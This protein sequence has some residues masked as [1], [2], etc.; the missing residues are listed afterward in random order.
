MRRILFG[1]AAGTLGVVG[2]AGTADVRDFHGHAYGG[3]HA[4]YHRNYGHRFSGG[5]YYGRHDH[6]AW[7]R[8]DWDAHYR[9]WQYWDPY[10][11]AWYYWSPQY[12]GYYPITYGP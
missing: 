9:R 6:P 12:N 2:L 3:R 8:R 1:L 10:L 5:Y 4:A 7:G 11:N